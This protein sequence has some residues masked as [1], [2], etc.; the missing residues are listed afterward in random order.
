M[1]GYAVRSADITPV[2]SGKRVTLRVVATIT[3]GEFAPRPLTSAEIQSVRRLRG[4]L[5]QRWFAVAP[6]EKL[7]LRFGDR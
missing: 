1:D 5:F 3:A 6:G 7:V 2:M 4:A